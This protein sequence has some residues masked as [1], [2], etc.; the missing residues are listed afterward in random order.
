MIGQQSLVT[1]V[2]QASL[3][4]QFVLALLVGASVVSWAIIFRKRGVLRVARAA[5][6]E[7]EER[8]WSGIDLA[9]LY[10][11]LDATK[12]SGMAGIFV[13][14]FR[15]FSRLRHQVVIGGAQ[16][17]DGSRRA[18]RVAQLRETDRLEQNLATLATVGSTSPYVGLFGTVWGIMRAFGDMSRFVRREVQGSVAIRIYVERYAEFGQVAYEGY[19]RSDGH[20]LKTSTSVPVKLLVLA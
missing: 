11:A 3:I 2:L 17:I 5:A 19:L 12:T 6:D 20:L 14:G 9:V 8:F 13:S 1:L 4:V 7:F 16:L 18:M 10:K 15:E